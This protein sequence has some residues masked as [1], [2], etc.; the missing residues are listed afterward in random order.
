MLQRSVLNA[1]LGR[2]I[3]PPLL[4]SFGLSIMI[5]NILLE[6][7]SADARSLRAGGLETQ[8]VA[9]GGDLAVGVL[10]IMTFAVAL[11]CTW[12]LELLFRHTPV[13]RAFRAASD[14][15][16]TAQLQG[17]DHRKVYAL[18]TAIAFLDV[19]I[20]G[21]FLALRTT[22]T[23]SDGPGYL[24]YSFEAVIIGGLGSFWGTFAGALILGVAQTA[25]FRWDPGWGVLLGHLAFLGIL[26]ARPQGL[27]PKTRD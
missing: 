24:L 5:E 6:V 9:L 12:T 14:D 13:G 26:L 1:A 11:G 21:V 15:P 23:P 2:G 3:L 20:A 22:V 19:A 16:E 27:F 7:F 4:V 17:V 18:A 10:P 25:G 8:S